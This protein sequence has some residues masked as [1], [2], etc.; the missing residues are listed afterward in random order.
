M[1]G[2]KGWEWI[3]DIS[4]Y[5]PILKGTIDLEVGNNQE[6]LDLEFKF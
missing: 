3:Y 2:E 5:A 4:E 1:G 6:L